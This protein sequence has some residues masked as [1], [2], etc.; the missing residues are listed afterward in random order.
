MVKYILL[1]VG[2]VCVIGTL[3]LLIKRKLLVRW[4]ISLIV[5]GL[6]LAVVGGGWI[7]MEHQQKVK[8][9]GCIYLALRYLEENNTDEAAL[10]LRRT[11]LQDSFYLLTAQVALDQ[12]RNN[13]TMARVRLDILQKKKNLSTKEENGIDE[14]RTW[15][16]EKG[17]HAAQV[18]KEMLPLTQKQ[19]EALDKQ[20]EV[21]HGVLSGE[22]EHGADYKAETLRLEIDQAI[23]RQELGTALDRAIEL[24]G[25]S[26]SAS[27]RLLLASVVAE[28][29][30]SNGEMTTEQFTAYA[31]GSAAKQD[32]WV[33]E[34]DELTDEYERLRRKL[35]VVQLDLKSADE[36]QAE[37]LTGEEEKLSQQ[38]EEAQLRAEN[39]FA[40]RALNSIADIHT[41]K[42][43][44]VRAKLYF[45]VR[46]YQQAI[47]TLCETATSVQAAFSPDKNLTNSLKMVQ[48]AYADENSIGTET[49]EFKSD[50]LVLMGSVHPELMHFS[51]SP[52]SKAFSE[53]IVDDQK[54][55]GDGLYV[56]GLDQSEYPIVHVRL[57]GR[58]KVIDRIASKDKIALSDTRTAV[59]SFAVDKQTGTEPHNS[60]CFVVDTSGSMGGQPL[61]DVRDA[62]DRFLD[63]AESR[64][65][66][67]L[68]QFEDSATTVVGLTMDASQ[69]QTGAAA[70]SEG[71]GTDIN[72]GIREGTQVL[73]NADGNRTML[74]MTDG[75]SE[76]DMDVVREAEK[77][78]ITIFTI[79]FGDVND[80]MLTEIAETCGGQYLRAEDSTELSSVYNSLQ[81]IIGNT[82]TLTYTAE[83]PEET[84]RY[85]YLQDETSGLSVHK[86]YTPSEE[87]TEETAAVQVD[88]TPVL[89]SRESLNSLLQ[90]QQMTFQTKI[91]GSGLDQVVSAKLGNLDCTL[92]DQNSDCLYLNVP[93]T[94]S[95]G[96]YDLELGIDGG[97]TITLTDWLWI[98]SDVT[99]YNYHAGGLNIRANQKALLMSDGRLALGESVTLRDYV[100]TTDTTDAARVGM[101]S[102]DLDGILVFESVTLPDSMSAGDGEPIQ[103]GNEGTAYIRGTLRVNG[104]DKA[105][106]SRTDQ[107]IY[108]G[109]MTLHYS[110]TESN[111]TPEEGTT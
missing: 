39:V 7:Q 59:S 91:S 22:D 16:P 47:D 72:S 29:T 79:G 36:A 89:Q 4:G 104:E 69:I 54:R 76:V 110:Q 111:I 53:R 9:Y 30:Y 31:P 94:V 44:V 17:S 92:I 32:T 106:D 82:V 5:C 21:E 74:L 88:D 96:V 68:V 102:V 48:T 93:A 105:Y 62:L 84:A 15:T 66:M 34:T 46:S 73:A 43:Q 20:F 10:R 56:I 19:I 33:E 25:L 99:L 45:A 42:A 41:L 75:Q 57:G 27:D 85:F 11:S 35:E 14:L 52:L 78:Q 12:L 2:A 108:S 86:E 60:I 3:V 107:T 70:M 40:Y 51:T 28:V 50:V 1:A 71:G 18:L 77:Q 95:D 100:Q 61:Q 67:A 81:G 103:L 65:E 26:S 80:Q 109:A 55:Y 90:S 83:T 24:V 98:G 63:N 101:L 38:A 37:K 8:D 23:G 49:E 6:I 64:T 87:K 58:E 97:D 13:D